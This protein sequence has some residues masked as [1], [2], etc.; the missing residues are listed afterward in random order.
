MRGGEEPGTDS[1]VWKYQGEGIVLVIEMG[2]HP[3]DLVMDRHEPGY[4]DGSVDIDGRKAKIATFQLSASR[5]AY[6]ANEGKYVA[7]VHFPDI[8][9]SFA[10][11]M[12][13]WANCDDL[14]TQEIA[15]QIFLTVKFK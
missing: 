8:G 1:G 7:A 10:T 13:L 9:N 14:A 15:K 5:A 3:T 6:F 2:Q 11:R 4:R 12:T